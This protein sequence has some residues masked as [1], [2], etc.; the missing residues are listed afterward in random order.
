MK[1]DQTQYNNVP[2]FKAQIVESKYLQKGKEYALRKSSI[3]EKYDF[4]R[5]LQVIKNDELHD[6]FIMRGVPKND[7]D[8]GDKPRNWLVMIDDEAI[9]GSGSLTGSKLD[10]PQAV[11]NTISFVRSYYGED[12]L[13]DYQIECVNDYHQLSEQYK[14]AGKAKNKKRHRDAYHRLGE[15]CLAAKDFANGYLN[16]KINQI[17]E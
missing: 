12:A 3:E 5:A 2:S 8:P 14:T 17:L 16:Y 6:T 11:R 7:T 13:N 4:Y 1:I 10:G 9:V 15:E